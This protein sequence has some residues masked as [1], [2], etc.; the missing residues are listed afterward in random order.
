MTR[1]RT[2]A[3]KDPR[4]ARRSEER[5]RQ[6]DRILDAALR[7]FARRGFDAASVHEIAADAGFSVGHLYNLIGNKEAIY[8]AVL[9]REGELIKERI[10]G[11][12]SES[13]EHSARERID[14][15][16]GEF[17]DHFDGRTDFFRLYLARYGGPQGD[18]SRLSPKGRQIKKYMDAALL[19][20][21]EDGVRDGSLG[22]LDPRDHLAAYE[23]LLNG[24]IARRVAGR[25]RRPFREESAALRHLLWNG[26]GAPSGR[27]G[28]KS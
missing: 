12:L 24:F 28:G 10:R 6:R 9:V 27:R 8:E 15:I 19:E 22:P 14:R 25:S 17:L 4:A 21:M 13:R 26:I 23:D 7:R 16:T 5:T 20:L 1:T 18:P 3:I 11:A 2:G